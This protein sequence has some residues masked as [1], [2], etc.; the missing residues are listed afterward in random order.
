MKYSRSTRLTDTLASTRAYSTYRG[1]IAMYWY[2]GI[3]SCI[4]CLQRKH[5]NILVHWHQ[6][7]HTLPTEE[8]C[9]VLVH[10]HQLVPTLPTVLIH[11][12]QLVH[13]LAVQKHTGINVCIFS[14]TLVIAIHFGILA[15]LS[16]PLLKREFI[17]FNEKNLI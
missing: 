16:R 7:V 9:N 4:L 5:C 15:F 12:H 8:H 10:W 17:T 13:T 2:T 6:L 11:W 14:L 3:N 1:N